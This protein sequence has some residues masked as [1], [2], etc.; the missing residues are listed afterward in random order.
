M[1]SHC[2]GIQHEKSAQPEAHTQR[3]QGLQ[4]HQGKPLHHSTWALEVEK[5]KAR[6]MKVSKEYLKQNSYSNCC[7]QMP[8][9]E[10]II[11]AFNPSPPPQKNYNRNWDSLEFSSEALAHCKTSLKQGAC[12]DISTELVR[13]PLHHCGISNPF[14]SSSAPT[15]LTKVSVCNRKTMIP[16]SSFLPRRGKSQIHYFSFPSPSPWASEFCIFP[17][18]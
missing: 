15:S 13:I 4:A 2:N 5:V 14:F 8:G 6:C 9:W 17:G 10:R 12:T 1:G 7:R 3:S 18:V 16:S 11:C